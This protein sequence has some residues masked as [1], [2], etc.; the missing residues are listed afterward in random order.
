MMSHTLVV[1]PGEMAALVG[2][3]ET[4][5]RTRVLP[6]EVDDVLQAA[7]EVVLTRASQY[8]PRRGEPGAFV[9]GIVRMTV[10]LTVSRRKSLWQLTTNLDHYVENSMSDAS[11]GVQGD[12]LAFLVENQNVAEWVSVVS[13][14]A[15]TFEWQVVLAFAETDG[16]SAVVAEALDV[17]ASTVRAARSRVAALVQTVRAALQAR[18]D[19]IPVVLQRCLP[20]E[21]GF[22]EVFELWDTDV[23]ATAER[24]RL[25][26]ATVRRTRALIKRMSEVVASV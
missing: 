14:A 23:D 22:R 13:A 21:G 7:R 26:Q 16:S 6:H 2:R 20:P 1:H 19:G 11:K 8:D 15:S 5:V 12:P 25:S 24:L 17:P 18:D 3:W 4:F 10:K 9:F